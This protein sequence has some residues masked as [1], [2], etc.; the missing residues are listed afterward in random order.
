MKDFAERLMRLMRLHQ[1]GVANLAEKTDCGATEIA[2]WCK[3]ESIPDRNQTTVLCKTLCCSVAD[4]FGENVPEGYSGADSEPVFDAMPEPVKET[5]VVPVQKAKKEDV[6]KKASKDVLPTVGNRDAVINAMRQTKRNVKCINKQMTSDEAK[7]WL[8]AACMNQAEES[9]KLLSNF[10]ESVNGMIDGLK[11]IVA[12]C[13]DSAL[14]EGVLLEDRYKDL[15]A[16]ASKASDEAI[17]VA[18]QILKNYKN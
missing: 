7:D 5:P 9:N 18:I 15:V 13:L 14:S 6:P 10:A 16:A 17:A 1:L 4:L 8:E 3:G 11:N 12:E 2:A